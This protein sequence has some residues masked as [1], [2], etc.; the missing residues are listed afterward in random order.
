MPAPIEVQALVEKFTQDADRFRNP[1]YNETQVRIEFVD[2]LFRALGWDVENSLQVVHED[3]VSVVEGERKK[4]KHPDYGFRLGRD[5]KFYVEAKKPSVDLQNNPEPAYQVR[6]YGWSKG[7]KI[8][9]LTD[10]EEFII[11]NCATQPDRKDKANIARVKY[12]KYTEFVE[13]WD[14]IADLLSF[15][16]VQ[17]GSIEK[18]AQEELPKGTVTVDEAFLR[19]MEQWRTLLAKDIALHNPNLTRRELNIAVQRTIDRLV[20]LR[21]CEDRN[22]EPYARLYSNAN[23]RANVYNNLKT[24][25][26][27]AHDKY[28]SGLFDFEASGDMVSLNI[29]ISDEPLQTIIKRLYYPNS[30]YEFSVLPSDIL[31]QVYERF[32]G[33]VIELDKKGLAEIVEKPEVRKAGGV[34]YTPTYI[35]DYIVENT[36]GKLVEGKTPNQVSSLRVLDP[37]CGSGSFLIGAYQFLMDWHLAYYSDKASKTALKDKKIRE[38]DNPHAPYALTTDEKKRILT[39]NI[40]GVDLDQQAVEVSK[41]SLLLKMLEDETDS[42]A[43]QTTMF[44]TGERILPDLSDNIKWGNSLI[45]SD[46]YSNKQLGMFDD[47]EIYRVKAFD[48]ETEFASIMRA[49]GFDAVIGNPPYIRIQTMKETAPESV[50][51][52]NAQYLTSKG[53]YDIYILFVERALKLLNDIGLIGYILPHKFFNAKYG[54]GLRK[55]ITS[56]QNLREIIHFGH[57]QV[58]TG[59][60]T[61]TCLLFLGKEKKTKFNYV[62]IDD[63]DKWRFK[64]EGVSGF[65]KMEHVKEDNWSFVIGNAGDLYYKL[66]QLPTKLSDITDRIF[67][68]LKTSADKIYI[69]DKI[70]DTDELYEVFSPQKKKNYFVEK[71]LFH[72]LIK[73]GDSSAYL[74][75]DTKR[76]I[77]FPYGILADGSTGLLAS[78]EIKETYPLTWAYLN[79]NKEYLENRERGRMKGEKWYGYVYPKALTVM[80]KPKIF[81]PDISPKASYSYDPNGD[82]FFTGGTAGGYGI[83]PSGN[84]TFEFV[85]GVL[86][87]RLLDWFLHQISTTMRGGWYSYESRYIEKLP[88]RTIDFDNPDDKAQHDKMVT[89]VQSM[90]DLHKQLPELSGQAKKVVQQQIAK[91][92]NDIDTLVYQLYDLT[93]E[94]IAIVEGE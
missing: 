84:Y 10:F 32:L 94:E 29:H 72:P 57:K 64:R 80:P 33:K 74:M 58:F 27:E 45:G 90:L 21:I 63:L 4:V 47:E 69:V 93:P 34:Y 70:N 77:L 91:T 50:P 38:T 20:F 44:A 16:A 68:G 81:T 67:Q 92:D 65:V 56:G 43:R 11:Y 48:W 83:T 30:P 28:N 71:T 19:E 46:F 31:G 82:I 88:I 85:L 66:L 15:E 25:Y 24:I 7:L 3:R 89:L 39:N 14:E 40:Y 6:R 36:V 9:V 53:N 79:D 52:Y 26:A 42:T 22:I 76:L 1:K 12:I 60:T 59:A 13:R 8:S 51:Y 37:A 49:G 75:K 17:N 87:S 73:G 35:V 62:E 55:I 54:M 5:V 61:Y 41:L 18:F 86:N 78:T 2:P 23:D